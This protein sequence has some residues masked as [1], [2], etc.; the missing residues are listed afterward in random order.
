MIK[1]I[2]TTIIIIDIRTHRHLYN[3]RQVSQVEMRSRSG[4]RSRIRIRSAF[5]S[6]ALGKQHNTQP[7]RQ[8]AAMMIIFALLANSKSA[9]NE[10]ER[11]HRPTSCRKAT[12]EQ[13][14]EQEN[15]RFKRKQ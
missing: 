1:I 11:A 15:K 5:W 9:E 14:E 4:I 7:R 8:G 3:W 13:G 2:T 12:R 10:P 6:G